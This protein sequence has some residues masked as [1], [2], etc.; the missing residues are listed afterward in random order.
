MACNP[1]RPFGRLWSKLGLLQAAIKDPKAD[2][3]TL[4]FGKFFK[5]FRSIDAVNVGSVGQRAA[6]LQSLKL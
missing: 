6:K 2:S 1:N 5:G 4:R 3:T